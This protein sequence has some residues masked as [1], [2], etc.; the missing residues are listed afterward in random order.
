MRTSSLCAEAIGAFARA[1]DVGC[2]CYL[3]RHISAA[4]IR[5][6][7][8]LLTKSNPRLVSCVASCSVVRGSFINIAFFLMAA[9]E[10]PREWAVGK[11]Q[12]QTNHVLRHVFQLTPGHSGSRWDAKSCSVNNGSNHVRCRSG[13]ERAI[14]ARFPWTVKW[15]GGFVLS[16]WHR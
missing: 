7:S 6:P 11:G 16:S 1:C 5:L 14:D 8:H 2:L 12:P 4:M 13:R 3:F 10:E 15:R 9:A